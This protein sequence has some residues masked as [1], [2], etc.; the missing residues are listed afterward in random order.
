MYKNVS[1]SVTMSD[2]KCVS[3]LKCE[4]GGGGLRQSVAQAKY[5]EGR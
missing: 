1:K 2:V 4:I 3:V 5:E